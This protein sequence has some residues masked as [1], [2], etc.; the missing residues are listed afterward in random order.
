MRAEVAEVV[1]RRLCTSE[2]LWDEVERGGRNGR[3]LVRQAVSEVT[4]GS[5]SAPEARAARLLRRAGLGPFEQN[6]R[7]LVGRRTYYADFLWPAL[8]AILE[9][10]SVEHH[11]RKTDWQRTLARHFAL[12][13]AGYSVTHVPPSALDDATGF[14]SAAASHLVINSRWLREIGRKRAANAS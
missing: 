14:I 5:R 7:L 10:D 1:Q 13:A 11:F 6:A 12:E 3:A 2:E 9:I 8:A 4:S